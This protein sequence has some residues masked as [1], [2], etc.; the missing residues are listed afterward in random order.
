[1]VQPHQLQDLFGST[2]SAASSSSNW[3]TTKARKVTHSRDRLCLIAPCPAVAA[4]WTNL[5]F[6]G[7]VYVCTTNLTVSRPCGLAKLACLD[8]SG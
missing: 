4:V 6:L 1:M 2:T 7:M 8:N 5:S 3:R